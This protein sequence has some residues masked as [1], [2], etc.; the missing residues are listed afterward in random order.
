MK[1]L[2]IRS[3]SGP[4]SPAFGLNTERYFF[5]HTFTDTF[6]AVE[7]Q[8]KR[9]LWGKAYLFEMKTLS[10][11]TKTQVVQSFPFEICYHDFHQKCLSIL[12]HQFSNLKGNPVKIRINEVGYSPFNYNELQRVF[13][14]CGN[15]TDFSYTSLR[16]LER[17][18][19]RTLINIYNRALCE[20]R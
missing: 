2:C 15:T 1:S 18:I 12:F 10:C 9:I 11:E 20:Y 8:I 6:C 16:L 17:S 19:S 7:M 14:R 3:Y 4:Y 13:T 5:M